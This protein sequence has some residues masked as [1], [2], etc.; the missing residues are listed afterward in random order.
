MKT[1][2]QIEGMTCMGCVAHVKET[3]ESVEGVKEV[4]IS[5]E[6]KSGV[7]DADGISLVDLQAALGYD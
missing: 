1:E 2:Y 5:L 3:L 4:D 6:N 7:I